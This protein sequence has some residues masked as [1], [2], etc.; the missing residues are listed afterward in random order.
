MVLLNSRSFA[1]LF[2]LFMLATSDDMKKYQDVARWLVQNNEWG[3]IS[4][5]EMSIK[6]SGKTTIP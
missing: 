1:L 5:S 4:V 3:T 6:G 2:S